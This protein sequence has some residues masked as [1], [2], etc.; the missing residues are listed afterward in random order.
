MGMGGSNDT[1]V[2]HFEIG[3]AAGLPLRAI[4]DRAL[5]VLLYQ[6]SMDLV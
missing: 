2:H 6:V 5:K 4:A 1:H 3:A